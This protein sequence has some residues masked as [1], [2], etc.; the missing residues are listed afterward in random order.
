LSRRLAGVPVVPEGVLLDTGRIETAQTLDNERDALGLGESG[1]VVLVT[2][3]VPAPPSRGR[4]PRHPA[5]H[6]TRIVVGAVVLLCLAALGFLVS[7]AVGANATYDRAHAALRTTQRQTRSA[8][9]ERAQLRAALALLS[10]RVANDTATASQDANQLKAAQEEL[11][12]LQQH[13]TQQTALIG[14]LHTCL[15]GVER[16]LN[17][18]S[19]NRPDQVI[20]ALQAVRPSCTSAAGASG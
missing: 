11:A 14:S 10:A 7:D 20:V 8:S 3:I 6:V 9:A 1:S 2:D 13:V 4:A 19:V 15:G 17:A 16:A 18:L 12:A 5:R